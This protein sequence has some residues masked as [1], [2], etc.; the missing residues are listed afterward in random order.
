MIR[1]AIPRH[2]IAALVAAAALAAPALA[3]DAGFA[4]PDQLD[5]RAAA[6]AA[7]DLQT[8]RAGGTCVYGT[9]GLSYVP[10]DRLSQLRGC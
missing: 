3:A 6:A 1:T 5:R 9:A 7:V 2:T 10:A 4:P 8:S